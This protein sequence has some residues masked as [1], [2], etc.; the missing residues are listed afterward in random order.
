MDRVVVYKTHLQLLQIR[1]QM[2]LESDWPIGMDLFVYNMTLSAQIYPPTHKSHH[3]S[4][5]QDVLHMGLLSIRVLTHHM[6]ILPKVGSPPR[7]I[8]WPISISCWHQ[9]ITTTALVWVLSSLFWVWDFY[10]RN[11]SLLLK[12]ANWMFNRIKAVGWMREGAV[13][14]IL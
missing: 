10:I 14:L 9:R 6:K 2:F 8:Q 13:S 1:R 5:R 12:K 3:S 11:Q 7:Q 4:S